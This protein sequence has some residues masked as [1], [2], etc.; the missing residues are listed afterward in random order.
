MCIYGWLNS[1][2]T[3][4]IMIAK[5]NNDRLLETWKCQLYIVFYLKQTCSWNCL[6][7]T[8]S[9]HISAVTDG[10]M[11][12]AFHN[13]M[14]GILFTQLLWIFIN[15]FALAPDIVASIAFSAQLNL[16]DRALFYFNTFFNK[17]S[18]IYAIYFIL[19]VIFL[20]TYFHNLIKYYFTGKN[21]NPT[22]N[23]E[24]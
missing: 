19:S 24:T 23:F 1:M 7:P 14:N 2:A 9:H 8:L 11:D 17:C 20:Q 13:H 3:Y 6:I 10:W 12:A 15:S 4:C 5:I 16:F 18:I 21:M 22:M